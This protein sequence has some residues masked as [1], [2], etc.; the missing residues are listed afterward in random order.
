ME[1]QYHVK[2]HGVKSTVLPSFLQTSGNYN[3][4]ILLRYFFISFGFRCALYKNNN[5]QKMF[6]LV[7]CYRVKHDY[8][9]IN[10][11]TVCPCDRVTNK[12]ITYHIYSCWCYYK[13][14]LLIIIMYTMYIYTSQCCIDLILPIFYL[15]T[16]PN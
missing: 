11:T 1:G 15:I 4:L 13:I 9:L 2:P 8:H 12:Y 5:N 16:S 3:I 6:S 7:F 10:I 14:L